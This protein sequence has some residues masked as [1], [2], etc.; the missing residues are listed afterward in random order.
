MSARISSR[1]CFMEDAAFAGEGIVA[2]TLN[3]S[4]LSGYR[5]GGTIH[6]IVNNQLGFT[7]TP[8]EGRSSTYSTDVAKMVQAPVFHVNGDEP[9]AAYRV[10]QIALDYRRQYHKDV[11]IDLIGFRRHGHNEGDEPTNTSP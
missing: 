1:C 5:T 10:L 4:Q 2:E 9:E 6:I 11:V 3:L 7:T 8:D